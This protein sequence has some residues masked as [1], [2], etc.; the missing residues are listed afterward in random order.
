MLPPIKNHTLKSWKYSTII[1]VNK[2]ENLDKLTNPYGTIFI[3]TS[4]SEM[5]KE[6]S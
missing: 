3:F 5:I 2:D 6:M 4:A 1:G